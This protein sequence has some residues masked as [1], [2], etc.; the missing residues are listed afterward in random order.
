MKWAVWLLVP[1]LLGCTVSTEKPVPTPT[2]KEW[3]WTDALLSESSKVCELPPLPS[4]PNLGPVVA[5]GLEGEHWWRPDSVPKVNWV[6]ER[7]GLT[8]ELTATQQGATAPA[9]GVSIPAMPSTVQ[10]PGPGCWEVKARIGDQETTLQVPIKPDRPLYL[11]A[12]LGPEESAPRLTEIAPI[13]ELLNTV[14]SGRA[15]ERPKG[16]A[17][18]LVIHWQS[19]G[20]SRMWYYPAAEGRPAIVALNKQL[21]SANCRDGRTLIVRELSASLAQALESALSLKPAST[22]EVDEET[23]LL[24]GNCYAFQLKESR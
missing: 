10:F 11:T 24:A 5:H 1:L 20:R 16:P 9:Y 18:V 4:P 14:S 22:A 15:V 8:V 17:A 13:R 7:A 6:A 12:Q 3:P 2:L 19:G 21:V 23:V